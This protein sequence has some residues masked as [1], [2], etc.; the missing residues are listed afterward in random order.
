VTQSEVRADTLLRRPPARLDALG[1]KLSKLSRDYLR[2]SPLPVEKIEGGIIP[3]MN[4]AS[5]DAYYAGVYDT[6]GEVA[7][8]PW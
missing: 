6:S 2:G 7:K 8:H 1:G 3:G 4:P 5:A